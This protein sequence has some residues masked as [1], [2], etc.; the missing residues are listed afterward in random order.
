MTGPMIGGAVAGAV[1]GDVYQ[2]AKDTAANAAGQSTINHGTIEDT[3]L[4]HMVSEILK[5][6]HEA[7]ET[8]CPPKF[9]PIIIHGNETQPITLDREGYKHVSLL[10]AAAFTVDC[11][12]SGVDFMVKF[13]MNVGWNALDL[14]S[15]TVLWNDAG[16]DITVMLY[17]G[18]DSLDIPGV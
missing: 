5:I 13:A 12:I 7:R 6:I 10:T 11:R 3:M 4:V 16:T 2:K 9:E 1:A 18:D 14:P 15:R 17:K 8:A